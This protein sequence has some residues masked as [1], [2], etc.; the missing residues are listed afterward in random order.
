MQWVHVRDVAGAAVK[1]ADEDRAIG[2]AYNLASYPPISQLEF[3]RLLASIAGRPADV[4]Y[5]RREDITRRGGQLFAPPLYFGAYLDIPL[6][7][8]R[9]DRARSELGVQWTPLEDGLRETYRWYERQ[10]RPAPDFSWE[11][12]LLSTL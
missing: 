6:A 8:A 7:I 9:T 5:V 2:R 12:A 10:S 11:D 1:A 3:V 4:V